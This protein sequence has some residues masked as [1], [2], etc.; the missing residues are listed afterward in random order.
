MMRGNFT[1]ARPAHNHN[2]MGQIIRFS[3][4]RCNCS[5]PC[6]CD[7]LSYLDAHF[8]E[9][10]SID[11]LAG[12][13]Y[14]SKYHLMREFKQATGQTIHSYLTRRRMQAAAD[15]IAAG[16]SIQETSDRVG[17]SDYSLFYK[18]FTRFAGV[19][20]REYQQQSRGFTPCP[21][22]QLHAE[23]DLLKA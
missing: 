20:P 2:T 11:T 10:V 19:S 13:L 1:S 23:E 14:I 17:Y 7:A 5:V 12:T 18:N 4:H 6:V 21:C 3:A 22:I 16:V 9:A 15:L 8:S